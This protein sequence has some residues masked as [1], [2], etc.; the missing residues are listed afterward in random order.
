MRPS[1]NGVGGLVLSMRAGCG[2][3]VAGSE[4]PGLGARGE[5]PRRTE[6]GEA[7]G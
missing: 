1:G 7:P 4:T 5:T 6:T 2:A 3:D